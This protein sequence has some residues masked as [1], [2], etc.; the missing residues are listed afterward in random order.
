MP[1]YKPLDAWTHAPGG[2]QNIITFQRPKGHLGKRIKLPCG[3][4][5][6]CRSDKGKEWAARC[7]HEASQHQANS[8]I[9]LTYAQTDNPSLHYPDFQKFMKKL[10][11]YTGKKV[12]FYMCGE[13]G[14]NQ[15]DLRVGMTNPGLGRQHF[16]ALIFGY[17]F[18][19]RRPHS[20][21]QSGELIYRSAMLEKCWKKGF[22]STADLTYESAAYVARYVMKK[23]TGDQASEHYIKIDPH[24]MDEIPVEPEMARMSRRPGI[25]KKWYDKYH[26]DVFPSD[27][28]LVQTRSG[29]RRIKTP[30]YY[31]KLLEKNNPELYQDIKKR[32]VKNA[33]KHADNNTWERL[34]D[35]EYSHQQSISNQ[36]RNLK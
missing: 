2:T 11:K 17:D 26:K 25:G 16:H 33:E 19:D 20:R 28:V 34:R 8:F 10:R 35:R 9:T 22:S 5:L 1:C 14:V 31:S 23:I 30:G 7:M 18:P 27:E 13:Y 6:G 32:R 29:I 3:Q 15:D 12:R 4:C 36:K 24:T 21:T